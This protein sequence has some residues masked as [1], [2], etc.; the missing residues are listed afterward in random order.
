MKELI[1]KLV[2]A[3]GPSG[4]EE[5]ISAMIAEECKPYADE[6]RTDALG[7][8]IVRKGVK[9]ETG[10]RVMVAGHMDE[11][12]VIVTKIDDK[13][14]VRFTRIGGVRTFTC[15]GGARVRFL[16]GVQGVVYTEDRGAKEMPD[17]DKLY[18]DVG[19][20]NKKDCPVKVGDIAVFERS[21]V[22]LG[23]NRIVAKALDDRIACAVMIEALKKLENSVNEVY[24]VFTVMEE[25]GLVG[26]GTSAYGLAPEVGL[27]VDV[28][29]VGDIP[30]AGAMD[31]GLGKGPTVKVKDNSVIAHPKVVQ[32]MA[33]TAEEKGIPFQY[34]VMV[35]G[36]TDAGAIYK[37]RE[38]AYTGGLSL[39]TRYVHSPSEMV[40][41][42]DVTN[43]VELLAALL[44]G[45]I[46]L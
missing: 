21:M 38:G 33:R 20:E 46:Q 11:I 44:N 29:G 41:Y 37:S 42:R 28:C 4:Y 7:N 36:G 10:K 22:E 5:N 27:A 31:V 18:I 14:F 40:D 6:I 35:G 23:E 17:F 16:N 25:I 13:G 39:P 34:E 3:H 1:K 26:A 12:G 32:W 2:E 15:M 9:K 24:M 19:V 43:S 30:G 45:P 8:L